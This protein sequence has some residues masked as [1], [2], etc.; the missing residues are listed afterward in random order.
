MRPPRRRFLGAAAAVAASA[1]AWLLQA[2][3]VATA[4]LTALMLVK[5]V[6]SGVLGYLVAAW[7]IR[8]CAQ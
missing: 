2:V 3:G 8:K 6:Y 5:A 1:A 4:S 7:V